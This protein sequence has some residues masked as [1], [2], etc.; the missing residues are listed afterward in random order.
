MQSNRRIIV[1][2]NVSFELVF[3]E[4]GVFQM[5]TDESNY[6]DEKPAHRVSLSSYYIGKYPVTQRLWEEIIGYE[7]S[8]FRGAS[9]PVEQV[10]WEESQD[11]IRK[12]NKIT[13]ESFRLPSEAEWEFAARG[14]RYSQGYQYAGSDKLKQVGWYEENS[15]NETKEVGQLLA[16]EL[17]IHD[18]SGNVYEWCSDWFSD[19]YYK[20]CHQ[21]GVVENP[22]GPN[23]GRH[24][25]TRGGRYFRRPVDCRVVYRNYVH[26]ENRSDNIGFRLV[27][28]FTGQ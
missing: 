21:K 17:G 22:M 12:L 7:Q 4:G 8:Y 3:V 10:S 11:F 6:K 13:G 20:I 16:N 18:M 15:T 14:G 2:G 28:P 1:S 19:E 27:L 26:P 25:V 23:K 9:R 5:G 24:R